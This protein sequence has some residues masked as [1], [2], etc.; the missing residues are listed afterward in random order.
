[1]KRFFQS[2]LGSMAAIW[3]SFLLLFVGLFVMIIAVSV[4]SASKSGKIIEIK[5]GSILLVDLSKDISDRQVPVDILTELQYGTSETL[6]LNNA[7]MAI[8]AAADDDRIDGIFIDAAGGSAGLAQS[9]ELMNAINR[10]KEKDKWVYAY[11]DNY[12]QGNYIISTVADSIF[13]NPIGAVDIHGLQSTSLYFKDML[14]RLGI[15]VQVVKVGTYK[16]AVEP[17]LLNDMSEPARQQQEVYLGNIWKSLADRMAKSRR[18]TVERINR[19]ADSIPAFRPADFLLKQKLVDKLVYRHEFEDMLKELTDHDELETIST[20]DYCAVNNVEKIGGGGDVKIGIL[21]AVGDITEDGEDGIASSTLVPQ[22]LEL[23]ED[24]EIDG[25]ILRVNSGGGSAFASEQIWEALEQYKKLTKKPFYVSMGDVAASGGYYISCGADRIYAQPVTLTGSIGIFGMIPSA[26]TLFN[27]KLG[28]NTATV[29]TNPSGQLPTLFEPMTPTM[30]ASMQSYVNNGYELFTSRVA[31]GRKI[32]QDSVK[33]IGEGRVWDGAMAQKIGLVDK[34][35]GLDVAIRDMATQLGA[36]SYTLEE[37]PSL[38]LK[39]WQQLMSLDSEISEHMT[40]SSL[41][42][43]YPLYR[44]VERIK[45]M[46]VLQCRMTEY[47]I[48]N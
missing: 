16:S 6:A 14:D 10:F 15:D 38:K 21:Y 41:G 22:I 40:R 31:S 34:L 44:A 33:V 9:Y 23:A 12:T 30:L 17:F 36:T 48:I 35:G 24:D 45:R 5:K 46:S 39:W 20:D 13:L 47:I 43:A 11:S 37:Y 8:D 28:I 18:L 7:V 29:S 25:L 19:I 42:E 2:F 32:S 3:L 4:S 26:K 1:M 27:E